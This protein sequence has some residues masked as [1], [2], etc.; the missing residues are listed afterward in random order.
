MKPFWLGYFLIKDLHWD[1]PRLIMNLLSLT[2][3]MAGYLVL[4]ALAHGLDRLEQTA[5][6]QGNNLIVLSEGVLDP[7]ESSLDQDI[8]SRVIQATEQKHGSQAVTATSPAIFRHLRLADVIMQV[9]AVPKDDML[10]IHRL[11]LISGSLPDAYG[12]VAISE[13][14][15][16]F[17]GWQLGE[18]IQIYG[19]LFK[20]VGLV[21][22]SGNQVF[23]VWLN[24][25]SGVQLFGDARGFQIGFIQL[26]PGLDAVQLCSELN[27]DPDFTNQYV[28]YL[29]EGYYK[30]ATRGAGA[31]INLAAVL[32]AL[33][34]A[35]I[36]LGAFNLAGLML[37]ERQRDITILSL[38]G[39]SAPT[40][41]R[42]IFYRTQLQVL[43]AYLTGWIV[44]LAFIYLYQRQSLLLLH[45]YPVHLDIQPSAFLIGIIL[46]QLA[47]A[48]GGGWLLWQQG[49]QD[50]VV[51]LKG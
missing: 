8:F 20:V 32:D 45:S 50:L 28:F 12:Q 5:P 27:E 26:N 22:A 18:S 21:R 9:Y 31:I 14:V 44:A 29:Q 46:S 34:L 10:S 16:H 47:A 3:I 48:F 13:E 35:S 30:Q 17:T 37:V 38:I 49:Q 33:A 40:I 51:L 24:F 43:L 11:Q 39:F 42:I 15:A 6:G 23:S 41:R 2:G 1:W 4:G 19:T 36:G 25:S 7:M